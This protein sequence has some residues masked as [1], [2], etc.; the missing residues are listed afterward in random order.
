MMDKT[1]FGTFSLLVGLAVTAVPAAGQSSLLPWVGCWEAAG[2]PEGAALCVRPLEGQA[3]VEMLRFEDGQVQARE[4]VWA[5]GQ[6]HETVR[7]GC[8]GWE[9]GVFSEDGRRL[10]LTSEHACDD[11]SRHSGGGVMTLVDPDTWLDV[12]TLDLGG[13]PTAWVQ[14]YHRS[15]GEAAEA[16]GVAD[17]LNER[18]MVAVAARAAASAPLDLDDVYEAT[19]HLPAEAVE[20]WLAETGDAFELDGEALLAMDQAGVPERV[21]DVVVAVSNPRVF[22]LGE[23]AAAERIQSSADRPAR[24]AYGAYYGDP[25]FWDSFYYRRAGYGPY[26][27]YGGAYGSGFYG[28]G[29]RPTVIVVEPREPVRHGR[30]IAGQGYRRPSSGSTAPSGRVGGAGSSTGSGAAASSGTSGSSGSSSGR[31]AKR[32]GGGDEGSGGF[33]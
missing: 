12:R 21:I 27:G 30:V 25:F 11:G 5:D 17:Y 16:S 19:E 22:R 23:G 2:A 14:R 33:F 7:E 9:Q 13:E 18:G 29:Y 28:Y 24:S 31:K 20:A 26:Y 32:R 15:W 10:F 4:V 8:D 1:T 3:A 6:R